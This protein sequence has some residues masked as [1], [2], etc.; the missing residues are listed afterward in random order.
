MSAGDREAPGRREGLR[1]H[2]TLLSD[3]GASL[4]LE[5]DPPAF[6]AGRIGAQIH[7]DRRAQRLA[8]AA[9][10]RCSCPTSAGIQGRFVMLAAKSSMG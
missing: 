4:E 2:P 6:D 9:V 10:P 5:Q 7:A 8:R 1:G 3:N